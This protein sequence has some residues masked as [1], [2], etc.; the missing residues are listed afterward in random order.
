[1]FKTPRPYKARATSTER[2]LW[3]VLEEKGISFM[4][5]MKVATRSGRSYTVDIF[6]PER[7]VIEVGYLNEIDIQELEDL[8]QTGYTVLHFRNKEVQNRIQSVIQIIKRAQLKNKTK[9]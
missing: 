6:I 2:K 7:L 5:Q 8:Q 9:L 3:R 1:L 4:A